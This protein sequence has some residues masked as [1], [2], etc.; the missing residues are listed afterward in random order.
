M[1]THPQ[2]GLVIS[3]AANDR[4]THFLS[5][6]GDPSAMLV[7]MYGRGTRSAT[8][9]WTIGS[10]HQS[11]LSAL[12]PEFEARGLPLLYECSGRVVAVPQHHL[13]ASLAGC[14]LVVNESGFAVLP[15]QPGGTG[16]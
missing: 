9:R 1:P 6:T 5:R 14:E 12:L 15:Q 8:D 16:I 4:V 2:L 10:Y 3:D 11:N 7:L 13:A